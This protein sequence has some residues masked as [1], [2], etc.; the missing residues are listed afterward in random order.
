MVN[1]KVRF[2]FIALMPV[3]LSGVLE[4]MQMVRARSVRRVASDKI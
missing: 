1:P 2:S 3:L 4:F